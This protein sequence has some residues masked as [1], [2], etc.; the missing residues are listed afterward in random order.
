M[1]ELAR[2]EGTGKENHGREVVSRRGSGSLVV[3]KRLADMVQRYKKGADL[4]WSAW[5]EV[6]IPTWLVVNQAVKKSAK[7]VFG[8]LLSFERQ[9]DE[10]RTSEAI[11]AQMAGLKTPKTV[12]AAIK[13]L[14][15]WNLI[16]YD[17][18]AGHGKG[19]RKTHYY[20]IVMSP[21]LARL[22]M[23]VEQGQVPYEVLRFRVLA[24]H[25]RELSRNGHTLGEVAAAMCDQIESN[26]P[27][28]ARTSVRWVKQVMVTY[29]NGYLSAH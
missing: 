25:Q 29:L 6:R 10:V 19:N 9:D 17:P 3:E 7:T 14:V 21:F 16:W 1:A 8:V 20:H 23:L 18:S 2:N 5:K 12:R 15:D 24:Q 13:D 27:F 4:G 26:E 11:L 22:A 28:K